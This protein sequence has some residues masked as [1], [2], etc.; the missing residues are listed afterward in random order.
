MDDQLNERED[1]FRAIAERRIQ[2]AITEGEFD[3]LAGMGQPLAVEEN[4]YVPEELRLTFKVMQNAGIVPDW[5]VLAQQIDAETEAW[6]RYGDEHFAAMRERLAWAV[7]HPGALRRLREE[8]AALKAQHRRATERQAEMLAELNR[9][10]NYF[11]AIAPSDSVRRAV[12]LPEIEMRAWADRLPA[13]L[14]Y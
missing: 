1:R 5:V 2:D 6:R 8:V 4:P 9:K 13:Y 14:N 12:F 11:N 7:A 3:N 10:I